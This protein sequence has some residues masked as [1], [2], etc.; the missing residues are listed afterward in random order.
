MLLLI[1]LSFSFFTIISDD[2]ENAKKLKN[3]INIQK[4]LIQKNDSLKTQLDS[5]ILLTRDLEINSDSR[6]IVLQSKIDDLNEN[7]E[8]FIKLAVK[9]Y[10]ALKIEDALE[11]IQNEL[12]ETKKLAQPNTIIF[13]KKV[14]SKLMIQINYFILLKMNL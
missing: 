8:P 3:Q 1:S 12:A 2:L 13:Q 9:K 6:N 11:K 10:P 5:L 4:T 7:L 14:I